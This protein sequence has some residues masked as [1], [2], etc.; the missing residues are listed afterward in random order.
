M[1]LGASAL[2]LWLRVDDVVDAFA[3]HGANGFWGILALGLFGNPSE[4]SLI[5]PSKALVCRVRPYVWPY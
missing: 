1:Y 5:G 2:V 3:V 4:G